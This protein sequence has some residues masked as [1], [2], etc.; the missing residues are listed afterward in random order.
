MRPGSLTSGALATHTT[1]RNQHRRQVYE[2]ACQAVTQQL[3]WW[4]YCAVKLQRCPQLV[5]YKP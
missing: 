3:L 2:G 4:L 1:V 5:P